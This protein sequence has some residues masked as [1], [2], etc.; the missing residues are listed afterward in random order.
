MRRAV[1]LQR[2]VLRHDDNLK[3]AEQKTFLML[4]KWD[5]DRIK[6]EAVDKTEGTKKVHPNVKRLTE[7]R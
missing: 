2:Y 6:E 1:I 3:K 7:M 4:S 5:M